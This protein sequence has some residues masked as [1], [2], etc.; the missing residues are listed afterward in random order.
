[1]KV[2]FFKDCSLNELGQQGGSRDFRIQ[3]RA[4][5]EC[6]A[7]QVS[8]RVGS[9]RRT[10]SRVLA[11]LAVHSVEWS[12]ERQRYESFG[13]PNIAHPFRNL[14]HYSVDLWKYWDAIEIPILVMRGEK[15]DL[16]PEDVLAGMLRR[17]RNAMAHIVQ[18]CGHAPALIARGQIE[19]V[20][21]FL[22]GSSTR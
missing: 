9:V 18:N 6:T 5:D 2:L 19:V 15:S 12:Q 4:V 14:W 3:N 22:K 13:D 1:M 10:G 20:E 16:L 21:A 17:N 11:S 8:A 7:R